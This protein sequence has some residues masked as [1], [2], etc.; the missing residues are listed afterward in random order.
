MEFTRR[1]TLAAAA[2]LAAAPLLP[3]DFANAAAP[4]ADKQAPGFY[5]YKVGD[6]EVTVVNDGKN[7]FKLEDSFIT[8]AKRDEVNAARSPSAES[9]RAS[10]LSRGSR[11]GTPVAA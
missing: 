3:A 9:M 6:I 5:R 10:I 2:G 11:P 7:V 4:V 1:H 8:N